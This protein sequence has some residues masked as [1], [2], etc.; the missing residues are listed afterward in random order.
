MQKD[1]N[2]QIKYKSIVPQLNYDHW[3]QEA[4]NTDR[5]GPSCVSRGVSTQC[6]CPSETL[7][8]A[9]LPW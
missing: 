4:R 6:L 7:L 3:F 1:V 5:R 9:E 2:K 8:I